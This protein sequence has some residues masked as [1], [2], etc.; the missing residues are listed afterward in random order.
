MWDGPTDQ[1]TDTVPY[2][3]ACTRLKRSRKKE[4]EEVTKRIRVKGYFTEGYC[5]GA[6]AESV[7]ESERP[8]PSPIIDVSDI[9]KSV[10]WRQTTLTLAMKYIYL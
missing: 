10:I 6:V 7:K 2:R 3:V 1:P 4:E 9:H 8:A 5:G